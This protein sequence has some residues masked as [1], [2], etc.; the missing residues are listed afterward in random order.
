[1]FEQVRLQHWTRQVQRQLVLPLRIELWNG[2]QI[3]L[4]PAPPRVTLRIPAPAALRYLFSPSLDQLGRAYV[5]GLIE[6]RGR[7]ADMIQI[8]TE[9]A[10]ASLRPGR[11][12]T[13]LLRHT[14]AR[15]AAAIRYHYDVSNDFYA[16]WLDRNMVYSCA[17]FEHGDETLGAAQLKKIDHILAKIAL[18][19][20]QRLLDVGC[21]WG[22]LVLR[23]AERYGA[24]CLGITLSENQ[25]ALARARVAEAGL[26]H[27]IEIRL[28]DYRDVRGEFER[29]TSVGMFEHVGLANLASYF[30][31][32]RS[33]LAPGGII[34]NHGIT[35]TSVDARDAPY[36]GGRFIDEYVFPHGELAHIGTVLQAMQEGGL[37]ARD[38]E[39]LRRH[40]ARTCSLW[41]ERFEAAGEQ[42]H[43]LV[44]ARRYR[45]WRVYLAGCAY[46]FAHDWVSLYQ[47]V[48][49]RAGEGPEGMPWSRRYMY[50]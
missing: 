44:D 38:V 33:L 48:C 2:Q 7:A 3:D 9:L 25:A 5:E 43:S 46:A 42:L 23:A 30:A 39:N 15:D 16:A 31:H 47:V 4:S 40:Y 35:S 20:G 29:I 21:G 50:A 19:P 12:V 14:R 1:M 18:Q 24:R 28:Q 36:G 8:V 13:R 41:A 37:E 10:R 22:A 11:S 17:Y 49:G 32:L 6:V 45:I 34:M 26:G 27:L